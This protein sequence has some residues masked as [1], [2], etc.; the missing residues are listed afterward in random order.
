[1]KESVP[2]LIE[3]LSWH[4]LGVTEENPQKNECS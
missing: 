1:M 4:V 3:I 2:G